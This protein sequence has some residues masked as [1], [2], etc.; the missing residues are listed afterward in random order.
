MKVDFNL[1]T[2]FRLIIPGYLAIFVFYTLIYQTP[3]ESISFLALI[4]IPI[5][6]IF[7]GL[8]RSCYR[9]F[10]CLARLLREDR[11]YISGHKGISRSGDENLSFKLKDDFY[12]TYAVDYILGTKY[13]EKKIWGTV[14]F[15]YTQMHSY[16]AV[17]TAILG[18]LLGA[19]SWKLLF[20]HPDILNDSHTMVLTILWLLLGGMFLFL[21]IEVCQRILWQRRFLID[22]N[23]EGIQSYLKNRK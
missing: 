3:K 8:Y 11:I 2:I 10:G 12:Y 9:I 17:G 21:R 20:P 6:L 7:Q 18:T 15:L 19:W 23:I 16:G 13:S 22:Q 14:R 5:G 4:G 1:D